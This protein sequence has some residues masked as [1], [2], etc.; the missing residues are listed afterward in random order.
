MWWI[1]VFKSIQMQPL[2][3]TFLFFFFCFLGSH[4]Q[5]MEVPRLAVK[6]ELQLLTYGTATERPDLSCICDLHHSSHQHWILN[7]LSKARDRTHL[8]MNTSRVHNLLSHNRNP[9]LLSNKS[10]WIWVIVF[11]LEVYHLDFEVIRANYPITP[12]KCC[13]HPFGV[14]RRHF[15]LLTQRCSTVGLL[16]P[17]LFLLIQGAAPFG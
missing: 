3:G 15:P 8:L 17:G 4:L 10:S 6:S 14:T 12:R 1:F 9:L 16:W 5:H 2:S 7:P 11:Q 13:G